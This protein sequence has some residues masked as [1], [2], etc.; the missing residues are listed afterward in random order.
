MHE[1]IHGTP[2]QI[3]AVMNAVFV[4]AVSETVHA[5]KAK[6]AVIKPIPAAS[7][8]FPPPRTANPVTSAAAAAEPIPAAVFDCSGKTPFRIRYAARRHI[9][10]YAAAPMTN[11]IT[12]LQALLLLTIRFFNKKP[13][14]EIRM[15]IHSISARGNSCQTENQSSF[16]FPNNPPDLPFFAASASARALEE[17]AHFVT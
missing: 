8:C 15:A 1:L 9:A 10:A 5:R 13:P 7:P 3:H 14:C 16:F 17:M 2:K 11:G 4:K 12:I 6:Y